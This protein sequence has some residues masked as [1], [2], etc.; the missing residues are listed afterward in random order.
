M[1]FFFVS[2]DSLYKIF[3][4]LGKIPKWKN[5]EISIDSHHS[6]F[7]N[8]WWWRQIKD[9]LEDRNIVATFITKTDKSRKFFDR[10]GLKTK[11]IEKNKVLKIFRML[12]LFIFDIKKFH[13]N[14]FENRKGYTFILV[15]WFEILFVLLIIYLLY[16]L[17]LPGVKIE[18]SP[19]QQIETVIYN[20]RYYNSTDQ[21]YPRYSRFISIPFYTGSLDYRYDMSMNTL[22][23]KYLQNPSH[24]EIKVFNKTEKDYNFVPNTRFVTDD[25]RLF[26]TTNWVDIPAGYEW[27]PWEKI[28][29]VVAM[30]KDDNGILMWSRWNIKNGTTLYVKNLKQSLF[31]KEIYAVALN[32]FTGGN[33]DT[34]WIITQ[35]DIDL[36]SDRLATYISQ[37][38]KNIAQQNFDIKDSLLL[39]FDDTIYSK[40]KK[41]EIPHSVGQELSILNWYVDSS[42]D[43]IYIKWDD[44][45]DSFSNYI[46]QRPSEKTQLLSINKNSLAFFE[47]D[48]I[49]EKD[50]T[51]IIPT[52]IEII[53][54]YDFNKD[55]GAV[56]EDI[57]SHIVWWDKESAR[58]YILSFPEISSVKIK[59]TPAWYNSIPKLKSRIKIEIIN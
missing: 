34:E 24:G 48:G 30:D 40:I 1:K 37:Q 41:I 33:L 50:G 4:T 28:I 17:I 57:K 49:I 53:Q 16:S 43:F 11:H 12:Y 2:E 18:I 44:L 29:N 7:D 23:M 51:F 9:V 19:S 3:K 54:W 52:K 8:D 27:L 25:G 22:N 55:V 47:E 36:L 38:K 56:L 5:V 59:I 6:L 45:I 14:T 58:S 20:F 32:D 10:I 42:I 46:K 15:F 26:K 31:L 39:A 13:L 35:K 21:D